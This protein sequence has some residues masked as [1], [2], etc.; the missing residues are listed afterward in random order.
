MSNTPIIHN[1]LNS[2]D[3]S[4]LSNEKPSAIFRLRGTFSSDSSAAQTAFSASPAFSTQTAPSAD[5]TAILG[6]SIEPLAQIQA[7]VAAIPRAAPSAAPSGS[8]MMVKSGPDPSLLAE[9][10]VKNLFNYLSGFAPGGSEGAI[11]ADSLVPMGV[12]AKWYEKFLSKVK[13]GGVGFLE[14]EE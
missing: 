6:F 9:R 8:S 14:N 10:V 2:T 12:I 7:Q 13:A 4:R 5:V 3:S 11:T 1:D